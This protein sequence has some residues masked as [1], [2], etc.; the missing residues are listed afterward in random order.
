MWKD[1]AIKELKDYTNDDTLTYE[2]DYFDGITVT[3][4]YH[5]KRDY[6]LF[7]NLEDAKSAAIESTEQLFEDVFDVKYLKKFI[8]V[9][10]CFYFE[11]DDIYVVA[12]DIIMYNQK[13]DIFQ[14]LKELK[15]D[16]IK[17]IESYD[18]L[19]VWYNDDMK[20]DQKALKIDYKKCA[21]KSVN[22]YG[23]AHTLD[24]YYGKKEIILPSG[25]VAYP[26]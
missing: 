7:K 24:A 3:S 1:D 11:D 17:A 16:P 2:Y 13:L 8:D 14:L 9:N 23:N 12:E 6:S 22:K 5:D 10:D 4:E 21:E 26:R 25:Y 19:Y 20:E 15:E 18:D